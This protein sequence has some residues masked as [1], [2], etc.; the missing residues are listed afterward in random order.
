MPRV[1]VLEVF[2]FNEGNWGLGPRFRAFPQL[3]AGLP[4]T[5]RLGVVST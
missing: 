3:K 5:P 1:S 2:E 4:S